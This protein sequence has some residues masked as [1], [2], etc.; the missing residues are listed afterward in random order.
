MDRTEYISTI[1]KLLTS[2][3]YGI[4]IWDDPWL[5]LQKEIGSQN[6]LREVGLK[7]NKLR[8]EWHV[9]NNI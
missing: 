9:G 1:E 3:Q 5:V 2:K 8:N 6:F 7:L 4:L